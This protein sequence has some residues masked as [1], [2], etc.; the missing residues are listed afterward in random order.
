MELAENPKSVITCDEEN[1]PEEAVVS[2]QTN[3][4]QYKT[5]LDSFIIDMDSFSNSSS[6][7]IPP[8]FRIIRNFSRKGMLRGG[9][10]MG[11]GHG[12]GDDTG[13]DSISPLGG[14][15]GGGSST[16]EKQAMGMG[17]EVGDG[18]NAGSGRASFRR[19]SLKRCPQSWRWYLDPRMVFLLCATVS[20][21]GTVLL[22]YLTFSR[23][24]LKE[25]DSELE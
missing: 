25:G 14:V 2:D 19:N 8:N 1:G 23:G 6:N 4:F 5:K 24:L 21:V 17:E 12:D 20:C 10:K 9:N 7:E 15:V 13:G 22:I 18:G 3:R 16:V 11:Q